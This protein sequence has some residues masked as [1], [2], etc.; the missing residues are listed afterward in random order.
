MTN[1]LIHA[2]EDVK[3]NLNFQISRYFIYFAL[4]KSQVV[5]VSKF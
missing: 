5:A 1:H 3:T 2:T 4:E